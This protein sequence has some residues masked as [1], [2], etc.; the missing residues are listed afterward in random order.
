MPMEIN[1]AYLIPFLLNVVLLL[2]WPILSLATLLALKKQVHMTD[3][4]KIMWAVLIIL[5]PI[6]GAA[7]YWVLRPTKTGQQI[8]L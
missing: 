1:Y 6:L 7:S 2:G 4:A 5:I 8:N 3:N